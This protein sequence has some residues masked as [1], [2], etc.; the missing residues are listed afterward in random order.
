MDILL[1][2]SDLAVNRGDRA[3]AHGMIMLIR[4]ALDDP[5]IVAIS[6]QASRDRRWFGV[7]MLDQSL[8]SL[9]PLDL[10]RLLKAARRSD[11]VLWGGGEFLKDYTNRLGLWY[12]ACKIVLVSLVAP[13]II[14]VFQGIGPTSGRSSRWIIARVVSRLHR[15]VTRDEQSREKLIAWGVDPDRV[16]SSFDCAVLPT[17]EPTE[18]ASVPV[19]LPGVDAEFLTSFVTV[20]PRAWFHYR[21]G[22]V[23]PFRWRRRRKP[24][25]RETRYRDR[26][27]EMIDTLVE[28]HGNVLLVP[29][30]MK[31]DPA[32]CR[33]LLRSVGRPDAVRLLDA[34]V[35]APT[36]LASIIAR[37]KLMVSLRLHAGIIASSVGVP[38]ITYYYVDKG[39]LFSEQV[40]AGDYTRPVEKLLEDDA[41]EDFEA[42]R[43]R[44]LDDDRA[45]TRTNQSLSEMRASI[46]EAFD[47]AIS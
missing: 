38:T 37:T 16:I 23:V 45:S 42:M 28:H 21:T 44:L 34:D 13:R 5:K 43:R 6:S 32:F 14:G 26:I 12:W 25:E 7:E 46:R 2:N 22:R 15:F 36:A 35:L 47:T 1:I 9:N 40:G 41:V 4:E 10:L 20:A 3:I 19:S 29:M 24:S 30:H 39:R 8:Y 33:D 17:H 18:A 27:V 31:E 11:I